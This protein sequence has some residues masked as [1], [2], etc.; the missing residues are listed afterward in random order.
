[1][2][3]SQAVDMEI[4][5]ARRHTAKINNGAYFNARVAELAEV[6]KPQCA[7]QEERG[8]LKAKLWSSLNSEG[9]LSG[10]ATGAMGHI[11]RVLSGN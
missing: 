11:A 6:F 8:L 2:Y 5:E 1:M 10:Q 7:S 4:Q 3:D 9:E